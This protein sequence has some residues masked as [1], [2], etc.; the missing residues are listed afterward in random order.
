LEPEVVC[1]FNEVAGLIVL[2]EPIFAR[3]DFLEVG[4]GDVEIESEVFSGV[5]S[6]EKRADAAAEKAGY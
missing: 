6:R 3:T 2:P 4:G 1:E 5:H